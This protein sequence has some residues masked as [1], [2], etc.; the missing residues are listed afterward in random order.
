MMRVYQ[1]P[2]GLHC[3][4][5]VQWDSKLRT[6]I[7]EANLAWLGKVV[8]PGK[9][10]PYTVITHSDVE[11]YTIELKH[12]AEFLSSDIQLLRQFYETAP[13]LH[14]DAA[15]IRELISQQQR[16]KTYKKT[17]V[18]N[19]VD[20]KRR[21]MGR[22]HGVAGGELANVVSRTTRSGGTTN[23]EVVSGMAANKQEMLRKA[24][25]RRMKLEVTHTRRRLLI[26]SVAAYMRLPQNLVPM[27]G[28]PGNLS[29][30][31]IKFM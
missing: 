22:L 27:G 9:A 28:F 11:L 2:Y 4:A 5:Q 18:A 16:W 23:A 10:A 29:C 25:R 14:L 30:A 21:Q 31:H 20:D 15:Y 6:K 19:I 13:T 7:H 26:V 8:R 12:L 3:T 1:H 17:L 24:H